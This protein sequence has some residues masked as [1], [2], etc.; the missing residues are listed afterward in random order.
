MTKCRAGFATGGGVELHKLK[1]W[2]RPRVSA[3]PALNSRPQD[4]NATWVRG[5]LDSVILK[6]LGTNNTFSFVIR[7][8]IW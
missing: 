3:N 7:L 4:G 6:A 5:H 2:V 1:H 8:K